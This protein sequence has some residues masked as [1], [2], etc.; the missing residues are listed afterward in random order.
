MPWSE[1]LPD[2]CPPEN[3]HPVAGSVYRFV[4]KDPPQLEDF[5]SWREMNPSEPCP[6]G[7]T[8][9]QTCGL[10]VFTT[11]EGVCTALRRKPFLREKKVALGHLS[12]DLDLGL[13]QNT[14]AKGTGKNHHTWWFPENTEA[15]K[16]FQIVTITCPNTE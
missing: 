6:K 5:L 3:A 15:W 11:E 14:P 13:I 4:D 12:P 8:E 9:C 1:N 2:G 10:S 16:E 7:L